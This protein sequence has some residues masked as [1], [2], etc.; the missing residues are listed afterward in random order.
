M[1]VHLIKVSR[2]REARRVYHDNGPTRGVEVAEEPDG[3]GRLPL[4]DGVKEHVSVDD[5]RDDECRV[6][7]VHHKARYGGV[8]LLDPLVGALE[9][10]NDTYAVTRVLD[11]RSCELV[12]VHVVLHCVDG[13]SHGQTHNQKVQ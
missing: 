7:V 2:T 1:S 12:Y 4:I 10:V 9:G 5:T 11:T 13:L 8:D 3:K 6:P